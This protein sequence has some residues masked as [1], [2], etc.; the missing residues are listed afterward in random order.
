PHVLDRRRR[1]P[2]AA[3]DAAPV[4]RPAPRRFRGSDGCHDGGRDRP[5]RAWGRTHRARLPRDR[6]PGRQPLMV[7]SR[8]SVSTGDQSLVAATGR[9]RE[10]WRETLA[11]AGAATWAHPATASWL[12]TEHG[13]D[14]WWAQHITVDF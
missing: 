4:T 13:V 5:H 1:L 7:V 12:V 14:G 10:Y 8:S 6:P 9:S 2:A 11:E 3:Q